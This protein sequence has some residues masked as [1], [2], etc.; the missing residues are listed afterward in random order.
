MII[1]SLL[2]TDLYK[3]TMM[4]MAWR[5]YPDTQ[6]EYTFICRNP[7][8][9]DMRVVFPTVRQELDNFCQLR[10]QDDELNYLRTLPYMRQEFVDWL[11]DYRLDPSHVTLKADGESGFT[12]IIRGPLLQ[13][14]L[15]EVP[16]LAI[17][18]ESTF[19]YHVPEAKYSL[20]RKRLEGKVELIRSAPDNEDFV[21]ADFG[22]RRRFSRAHHRHVIEYL[23]QETP[24]HCIGTSNVLLAKE[25]E[26]LPVGT[27]A[28]EYL[29]VCQALAPSLEES[30]RYAFDLWFQEYQGQLGVALS[31]IITLDA[32]LRDFDRS[33]AVRY[34]GIR[35]DSGDPF[36]WGDRVIAHLENLGVDPRRKTLIFS[37]S[38]NIPRALEIYHYF[39][40]RA[41]I[42]FG[43]GTNLTNDLGYTPLD[44]V[45]KITECNGVPVAK[46]SDSPGKMVCKDSRFLQQLQ[47]AFN[48]GE[49]HV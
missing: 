14:I 2:D 32:F 10:F 35:H 1:T 40:D 12:L 39:R 5:H 29:Q 26:L 6:V 18:N 3:L 24:R 8:I 34:D 48:V 27:M 45:I 22:T 11:R 30:Q 15:Y 4:Q 33:L 46:I 17:I 28:H 7:H 42:T 13:T 41:R 49:I 20:W 19:A 25:L 31:D 38:L 47:Q 44:I 16:L 9:Y 21:F 37:N 36:A 43:I 23:K